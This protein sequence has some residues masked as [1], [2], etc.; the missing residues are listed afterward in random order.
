MDMG[1]GNVGDPC[2]MGSDCRTGNCYPEVDSAMPTGFLGGYCIGFGRIP[3]VSEFTNGVLP[4]S[5]CPPGSVVLPDS[6]SATGD[7]TFCFRTCT[8]ASDCR[9]GYTCGAALMGST[10]TLICIPL[11][12]SMTGMTCP[13]GTTCQTVMGGGLCAN[14]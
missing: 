5:D 9:V 6:G 7:L 2:T 4:R 8:H 1:I 10:P 11:D 14:P 3:D 13:T 12:C